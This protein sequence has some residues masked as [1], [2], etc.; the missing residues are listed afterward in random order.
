[1]AMIDNRGRIISNNV[2]GIIRRTVIDNN[3]FNIGVR[4]SKNRV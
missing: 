2:L 1:M 4:L 3:Y